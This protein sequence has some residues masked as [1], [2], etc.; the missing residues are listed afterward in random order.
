LVLC[1]C[2]DLVEKREIT[3][4]RQDVAI[5][6][7]HICRQNPFAIGN[8]EL[9]GRGLAVSDGDALLSP[10]QV[11]RPLDPDRRQVVRAARFLA[12]LKRDGWIWSELR[13][14][15]RALRHLHLTAR[16]PE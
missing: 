14:D 3:N 5:P 2:D 6:H 12:P 15:L 16:G 11:E 7:A 9:G 10:E 1:R 4:R 13:L 8:S